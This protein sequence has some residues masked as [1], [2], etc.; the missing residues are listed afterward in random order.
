MKHLL[1]RRK[2]SMYTYSWLQWSLCQLWMNC[3]KCGIMQGA[4]RFAKLHEKWEV[5]II[6]SKIVIK[7]LICFGGN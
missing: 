6:K 1:T 4:G 7:R 3:G 2:L 5:H